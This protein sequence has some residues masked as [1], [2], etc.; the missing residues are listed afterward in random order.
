MCGIAGWIDFNKDLLEDVDV[1]KR[2][3][4]TLSR[5]GP[6][7]E[8]FY[9]NQNALL[10]HRRLVVVDPSGGKQPMIRQMNGK[11]YVIVY[12]G[13]LYNTEDLRKILKSNGYGF[14]SYSDT[15]VLL[16][17]YIHW[18]EECVKYL[19][20]IFAFAVWDEDEKSV[21]LCR[22]H[23][24]VKPLFYS[25]KGS[26]LIF[27]SEIKTVLK[28]PK[29]NPIVDLN[30]LGEL[31]ALGPSRPPG[32]AIFKDIKEI[33]PANYL[34]FNKNGVRM[35]EYWKPRAKV[36]LQS[37]DET[38]EN[39]RFLV[40]DAIKRQLVSDVPVCSFLS[41][42][43]DSSAIV[44][45]AAK[46]YNDLGKQ[47]NT[48]S[49]D[50][51]D[52]EKYFRKNEFIPSSDMPYVNL[53]S[54]FVKSKH[55][56]I[57]IDNKE[58]ADYLDDSVVANDLPGMADIDSSLQIF[59]KEIKK[60]ATVAL[61]GECA[62]EIFGGYPWYV[63]SEDIWFDSFPWI[64]SL[65]LR[66]YFIGKKLKNKLNLD[67]I[68]KMNYLKT[69]NDAEKLEEDTDLEKRM[70]ELF[71][72]NIKWFMVTLLNRKDRMSMYNS[73]EVR[74]PFADYRIVEYLYNVPSKLK[75]L[76]GREKGLLRK[77]FEG[78]LPNEIIYRKKSPYPKIHNPLYEKIVIERLKQI[79]YSPNEP[80][81]L[82]IDKE[83]VL[84]FLDNRNENY[85][86]TWFGQLMTG[87]QVAAYLIQINEWIKIYNVEFEL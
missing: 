25:I 70:R 46:E 65:E 41:G 19:N 30:G 73:L 55:K 64:K 69:I 13:E 54:D 75:F 66:K 38:V 52:N 47:L 27:G 40:Q 49:I 86:K 48:Y 20:G 37:L 44:A 80:I 31:F 76:G 71:Y 32:S 59:T 21:F 8:G 62:D 63:K 81:N 79:L 5:R 11:K 42:G 3:T 2:M 18:K 34:V 57:V 26:S 56:N 12:N 72:L 4:K 14:Q 68:V 78:I 74:V 43:L 84:N 15:E 36:H 82:I 50:Y 83:N 35:V 16:M 7:D 22:D 53:M 33:P 45:V 67:E 10:G 29:V 87:P 6:D 39:V 51:V 58:L 9:F 77:A 17:S 23:L 24:G 28:H 61:S 60:D 85:N 1:I